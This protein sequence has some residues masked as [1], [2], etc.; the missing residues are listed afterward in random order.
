MAEQIRCECPNR[1]IDGALDG[2]I[3]LDEREPAPQPHESNQCPGT[4]RLKLIDG[5]WLCSWCWY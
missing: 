1:R 2:W 5:L 3:R 4:Y